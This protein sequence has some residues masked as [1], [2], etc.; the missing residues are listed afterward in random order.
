MTI[1]DYGYH[2]I[3]IIC[4]SKVIKISIILKKNEALISQESMTIKDSR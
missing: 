2:K 1:Q 3:N 4:T